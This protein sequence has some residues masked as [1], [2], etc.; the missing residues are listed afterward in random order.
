[1]KNLT[2]G[3]RFLTSIATSLFFLSMAPKC[4]AFDEWG[5]KSGTPKAEVEQT[6]RSGGGSISKS[7]DATTVTRFDPVN[8]QASIFI[9][10]FCDDRLTSVL[11]AESFT[12]ATLIDLQFD[13][14]KQHGSPVLSAQ[15]KSINTKMGAFVSRE[16]DYTWELANDKT[17][18][19]ATVPISSPFQINPGL[20]VVHSD[21]SVCLNG[22]RERP[23]VNE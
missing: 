4:L 20:S 22:D 8:G 7:G 18:I 16:L 6:V 17:Q 13:L 2:R 10:R 9:L 14:V 1:M 11:K 5:F 3:Y 15:D 23:A 19:I 12:P 21:S